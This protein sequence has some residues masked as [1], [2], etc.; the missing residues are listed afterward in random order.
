MKAGWEVAELAQVSAVFTDGDWIET[1]DQAPEGIRL[2]QTGNIGSGIFKDRRE[3]ARYIDTATFERL[4]CTEVL[5]GDCLVSRLP[6]PVGRACLVPQAEEKMVTAVDCTIIRPDKRKLD[7]R[8]LVYYTASHNYLKDIDEQ[9][10]GTTR[11]RISRKNLGK[12]PIPLPSLEEQK[13]IVA[14]LDEAFECLDRA[15]AN[16][17]ANLED[18]R[19]FTKAEI[20]NLFNKG[21]KGLSMRKFSEITADTLIGLVRGK[22]EQGPGK[23]YAYV[24]MNNISNH[25]S[26]DGSDVSRVECTAEEFGRFC[27]LPGDFLFN[28]RNSKELVGKS[29]VYEGQLSQELVFNNNIMRVRFMQGIEARFVALAFRS[30]FVKKQLERMKSGTTS[31]VAIYHKSL[32]NLEIL[33]PSHKEQ[34]RVVA[35]FSQL[36]TMTEDVRNSYLLQVADL[37]DLRQSLLQKAFAGELT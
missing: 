2:V 11:K 34:L 31:V 7:P 13:Q 27:L 12:I 30:R 4:N 16:V 1:K 21:G 14:I 5:P 6:D 17:E 8:F 10:T 24:K 18:A 19:A 36:D 25:D 23:N 28:T 26:F 33:L 15:R 32:K 20:D 29:C 9:C 22:K 37:A 35:Q 3:K